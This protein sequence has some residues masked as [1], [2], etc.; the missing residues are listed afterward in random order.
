MKLWEIC[1]FLVVRGIESEHRFTLWIT[2]YIGRVIQLLSQE[3]S[4]G[5]G[6]VSLLCF[7]VI[8]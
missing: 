6:C 5:K 8:L 4:H 3:L 1:G 7:G 2:N